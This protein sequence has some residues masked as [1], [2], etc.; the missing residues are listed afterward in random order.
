M[1][2]N[3]GVPVELVNIIIAL[4]IFFV[5]SSYAIKWALSRF[6]RKGKK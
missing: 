6:S 4:I 3:A 1:Q 5:G 2:A